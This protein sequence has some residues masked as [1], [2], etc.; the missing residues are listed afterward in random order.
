MRRRKN[1]EKI[2]DFT[3]I[4]EI[5]ND[6]YREEYFLIERSDGYYILLIIDGK[7]TIFKR[8]DIDEKRA[9]RKFR[10]FVETGKLVVY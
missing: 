8:V 9:R 5:G 10:E 4:W 3:E 1:F 2:I 7:V 6:A